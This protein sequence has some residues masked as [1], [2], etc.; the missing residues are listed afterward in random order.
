MMDSSH[1]TTWPQMPQQRLGRSETHLIGL[2]VL[3]AAEICERFSFYSMLSLL[4]LYLHDT[5]GWTPAQAISLYSLYLMGVYISPPVGGLLA[6][7]ILGY[8]R[9]AIIGGG[10]FMVGYLL[11]SVRSLGALYT[12]LICLAIGNGL[13]K[14]NVSVMVGELYSEGSRLKDR[15]YTV[16]YLSLNI[17]AFAAPF[18]MEFLK[19]RFGYRVCFVVAAF[20]VLVSLSILWGFKSYLDRKKEDISGQTLSR[21]ET[22][23]AVTPSMRV[24]ALFLIYGIVVLFWMVFHQSGTTLTEWGDQNTDWGIS[25]MISYSINPF[26]IVSL[27]LPLVLLWTLLD[28]AGKEPSTLA[29]IAIGMALVGFTFF[30][31]YFAAKIGEAS[32]PPGNPYAFKV[33]PVWLIAAYGAV[34]LG[35]LMISPLGLSLVS[36]VA[37]LR[38]RGLMMGLW[39]F[40]L[41]IGN[42][43]PA[44][45]TYWDVWLH[46]TFFAVLGAAALFI[47]VVLLI[48]SKPLKKWMPMI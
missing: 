36:K 33:S 25:G 38:V 18:V 16:F 19:S 3:S 9:A 47:A 48:L 17:G 11:L 10:F 43:L 12:A 31:L 42:K 21:P 32:A 2:L 46:S 34:S 26:W 8:R 29:K 5:F 1:Q 20:G 14:P 30:I 45:G 22:R 28:K 35:E 7:L 41:A 24:A 27:A 39:F 6:D 40:V 15:A 4:T 23:E 13:F 44:I 37:P